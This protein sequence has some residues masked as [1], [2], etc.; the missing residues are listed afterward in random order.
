MPCHVIHRPKYWRQVTPFSTGQQT[1]DPP[2][3]PAD[4]PYS[5]PSS[6]FFSTQ[7]NPQPTGHSRHRPLHLAT[8]AA[9]LPPFAS[10]GLRART[11]LLAPPSSR[12]C[13][14][15]GQP[16]PIESNTWSATWLNSG[17]YNACHFRQTLNPVT[18]CCRALRLI[19]GINEKARRACSLLPLLGAYHVP[20]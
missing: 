12:T 20:I 8:A 1:K 9:P 15:L 17:V 16:R 14:L 18:V 13:D 3:H 10:A 6:R 7:R 19:E 5:V 11:S 4:L 2:R